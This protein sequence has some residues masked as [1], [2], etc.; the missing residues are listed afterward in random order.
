MSSSIERSF[1]REVDDSLQQFHIDIVEPNGNMQ[2]IYDDELRRHRLRETAFGGARSRWRTLLARTAL[3]AG[4]SSSVMVGQ[5][6]KDVA[7]V[8]D[9]LR[10]TH[11]AVHV[12]NQPNNPNDARRMI[13]SIN[14]L[15]TTS[16]LG[17]MEALPYEALGLETTLEYDKKGI[18]TGVIKDEIKKFAVAH[19]I[20]SIVFS[21]HSMGGDVALEVASLLHGD[22]AAPEVSDIILDC[23]P[24]NLTAV[25]ADRREAGDAML[26][27]IRDIPGHRSSR[28]LRGIGE[29]ASRYENYARPGDG[30][31]LTAG[32]IDLSDFLS[33]VRKVQSEKLTLDSGSLG[34][35]E[36]QY[37][38]IVADGADEAFERLSEAIDGRRTPRV[39]YLM[40]H[41]AS[42]DTT[43]KVDVARRMF[44]ELGI[45]FNIPVMVYRLPPGTGHANPAQAPEQY[46]QVLNE[47]IIP[48]IKREHIKH[49]LAHLSLYRIEAKS[50]DG[51]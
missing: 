8:Q 11:P 2:N 31:R 50:S 12:V 15:G 48:S 27:A 42:S 6:A 1:A 4:M 5:Y 29:V 14:G 35:L 18:D 49:S 43:V 22:L 25:H 38:Q 3:M 13:M 51:K 37:R 39:H 41:D 44:M 32:I 36:D 19:G 16:G 28:Y 20:E 47:R 33:E 17:I 10:N 26:A 45:D 30:S 21:G 7:T 23:T 9:H 34:L 40:P 24:P 46:T